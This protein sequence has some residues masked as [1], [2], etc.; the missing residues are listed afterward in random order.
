[1]GSDRRTFTTEDELEFIDELSSRRDRRGHTIP[2]LQKL[3]KYKKALA[4]RSDWQELDKEEILEYLDK[5]IDD[6][7]KNKESITESTYEA[8]KEKM[9][10]SNL[11]WKELELKEA[12][13]KEFVGEYAKMKEKIKKMREA[14]VIET[15]ITKEV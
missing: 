8:Q 12:K 14:G 7:M 6:E 11:E 1:M 9:A 4:L 13:E 2:R 3:E 10:K 5:A 15:R